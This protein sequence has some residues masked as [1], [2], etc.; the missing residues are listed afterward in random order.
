MDASL[1]SALGTSLSAIK[2]IGTAMVSVRDFNQLATVKAELMS[3]IVSSME[4]LLK[5]Q[6]ERSQMEVTIRT[7]EQRIEALLQEKAELQKRRLE[8][9]QYIQFQPSPGVWAYRMKDAS[10]DGKE[11]PSYCANCFQDGQLSVLQHELKSFMGYLTCH[12]CKLS[13]KDGSFEAPAFG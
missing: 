8:L 2:D 12:R 7:L 10:E 5:I 6:T 4:A 3:Q 9:D 13:I 1:L 11:T